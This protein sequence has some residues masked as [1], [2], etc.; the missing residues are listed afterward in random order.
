MR[1]THAFLTPNYTAKDTHIPTD[2]EAT[3]RTR[4]DVTAIWDPRTYCPP[5]VT[6]LERPTRFRTTRAISDSV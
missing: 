4:E 6:F 3:P 1:L 2:Y 5:H